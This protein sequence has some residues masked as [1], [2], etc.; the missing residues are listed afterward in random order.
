MTHIWLE[1]QATLEYN[2]E[3]TNHSSYL[4][5]LYFKVKDMLGLTSLSFSTVGGMKLHGKNMF[6]YIMD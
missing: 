3:E 5:I 2:S 4:F 6:V 1:R